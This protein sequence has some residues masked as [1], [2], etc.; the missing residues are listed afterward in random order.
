VS[1]SDVSNY[2]T[3]LTQLLTA[4]EPICSIRGTDSRARFNSLDSGILL[5]SP[6]LPERPK[7]PTDNQR[8][9]VPTP[10]SA[11][12]TSTAMLAP[13]APA[14]LGSGKDSVALRAMRSVRSLARI[15]SWAQLKNM[16]APAPDD[17]PPAPPAPMITEPKKKKKK[18]VKEKEKENEK[19]KDKAT[20]RY[21]GSSFE[22]GALTASPEKASLRLKEKKSILGLGLPSTMRL[23]S[24]RSG[25]TASSIVAAQ[26][27]T[28]G[29]LSADSAAVLGGGILGR[30]RSGSTRTASSAGSVRPVSV[31]SGGSSGGCSVR[32]DETLLETVKEVRE[33]E[34][35]LKKEKGST[36]KGKKSQETGKTSDSRKRTPLAAIFPGG[37]SECRDTEEEL[38]GEG[39][40]APP[41]VTI[42]EASSDG[43]G[44]SDLE[45]PMKRARPRPMSEMLLGRSRPKAVYEDE[46]GTSRHLNQSV[47]Y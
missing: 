18:K 30:A 16:P 5:N 24:M 41:I 23:P 45:T 6:V 32:W 36:K 27:H 26:M 9:R 29:R 4:P 14:Q 13:P 28:T 7:S 1:S 47:T 43:H 33:K 39:A 15:G 25:S 21:S 40:A 19:E 34:R 3:S 38:H 44:Q 12:L 22:A 35:A 2:Y 8:L 10:P 20:L 42:E 31:S 37:S 11:T 46:N 17:A